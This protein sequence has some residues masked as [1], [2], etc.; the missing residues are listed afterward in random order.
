MEK[1][2]VLDIRPLSDAAYVLKFEKNDLEF[3]PGQHI[4]VGIPGDEDR[5]YSVYNGPKENAVEI[6]VKE[7]EKGNV[8]KKLKQ[9]Q[10]GLFVAVDDAQ[11]FFSIEDHL[12]EKLYFVATGTGIAPFHSFVKSYPEID[13]TLIH[14]VARAEEAYDRNDY[15]K[16]RYVLCTSRD[17]GGDFEGRVTNYLADLKV[18]KD[19]Y[20]FLCGNSAMVDEVYDILLEK[21]LPR[22]QIRTEI[23]F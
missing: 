20:F 22:E 11:G 1:H 23:Y 3:T 7:V 21:G 6:L 18:E 14:G 19:A 5:P 2:K 9:V 15:E 10:A 4:Y 13:Y 8:S 17:A 12:S 16:S